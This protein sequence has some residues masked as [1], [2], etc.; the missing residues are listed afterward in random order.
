M[1]IKSTLPD[2]DV[3][4]KVFNGLAKL[5]R[6]S[7]EERQALVGTLGRG[8]ISNAQRSRISTLVGLYRDLH[9]VFNPE[10]AKT[11]I[12]R[13][14]AAFAGRTPLEVLEHGDVHDFARVAEHVSRAT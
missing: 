11:W 1:S 9:A 13:P 5:W 6:L 7:R 8:S 10:L 2:D 4:L 14:N 3:F 12:R